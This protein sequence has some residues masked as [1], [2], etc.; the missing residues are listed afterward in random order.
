MGLK[1]LGYSILLVHKEYVD[2]SFTSEKL[3]SKVRLVVINEK[4][5]LFFQR[6]YF[7]IKNIFTESLQFF[8]ECCWQKLKEGLWYY[9]SCISFDTKNYLAR[10]TKVFCKTQNFQQAFVKVSLEKWLPSSPPFSIQIMNFFPLVK[11]P[12]S[13]IVS[14]SFGIFGHHQFS[15]CAKFSE[16]VIYS[17]T[18]YS[19][20]A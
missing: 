11:L 2:C 7:F 13:K 3:Q 4:G 6:G 17:N 15:T 5:L 12:T 19:N 20:T 9:L 18:I 8:G 14:E 16:N 1:P 10:Q